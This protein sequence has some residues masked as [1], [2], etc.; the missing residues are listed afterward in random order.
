MNEYWKQQF[1]KII[2]YFTRQK[3]PGYVLM[4]TGATILAGQ[5][6]I[7]FVITGKFSWGTLSVGT[8]E[9]NFLLDYIVPG[10]AIVLIICGLTLVAINEIQAIK[11]NSLKRIILITGDGLR[12]TSGTGL[13]TF[14]KTVL[15]GT[16]HPIE[17]DITQKIRNGVIIEPES[18]FKRQILPAKDNLV[19]LL[20]KGEQNITQIAYG[21]F[22]PIPFTFLLGNIIDDKGNVNVFDW[23]RE[24]DCWKSIS[25]ANADDGQSFLHETIHSVTSNEIVLMV[26]C[27]YRVSKEQVER[28]F[29]RMGIEHLM[30]ETNSFDNHWSMTKQRRLSM[31]FAEK[32]KFLSSQGIQTIHLVLAAQSSIALNLGRRYDNRNMPEIVVYQYEKTNNNPYP[33]GIY[34]LTHGR[35]DSGFVTRLLHSEAI[36]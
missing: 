12:T 17:I 20:S 21:G 27:S 32:V 10:L 16:I 15:K 8:A 28:S 35:E 34:G 7:S 18:T 14:V 25:A 29:P 13:V 36:E 3:R 6:A 33:W 23:D 31:Q 2:D 24:N 26:S 11:Q 22:L 30:L 19:Q 1:S 5:N 9:S 4:A